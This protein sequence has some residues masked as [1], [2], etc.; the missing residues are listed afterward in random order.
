MIDGIHVILYSKKADA[1]RAFLRDVIGFPSVDA[2]EGWLVFGLP[3]GELG[4]HPGEKNDV[5]ELYL[6]CPDVAAVVK[7]LAAKKFKCAPPMDLD[8]GILTHVTMPSGAKLGIYQ[9]KHPHVEAKAKKR[10][11]KKKTKQR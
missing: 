10:V 5:H 11:V 4:V 3:P 9:P 2:G 1:D 6:T 7:K 8:W